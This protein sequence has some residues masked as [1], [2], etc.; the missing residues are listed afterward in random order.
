MKILVTGGCGFI[1][2]T[3]I[4]YIFK[5][6]PF[7]VCNVDKLTYASSQEAL[8]AVADSK[9]YRFFKADIC[10]DSEMVEIFQQTQVDA[11]IHFAA[12]THVDRSIDAPD[13]FID[14][15]II[16]TYSLLKAA[17][18]YWGTLSGEK[19]KRFRFHHI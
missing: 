2:A 15:N 16:G 14:T 18:K 12:E 17:K 1:G 6:T 10:N 13:L 3:L 11:I 4:R 7:E 19:R 9:K 5:E 8:S